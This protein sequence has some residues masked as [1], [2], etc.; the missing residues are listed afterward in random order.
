MIIKQKSLIVAIVSSLIISSVLVLTLI[1]YVAYI[2]L[3]G[4]DF[5]RSYAEALQGVNAKYYAKY[6]EFPKLEARME[7]SG[8]LKG[9]PALVGSLK[10]RGNRTI[11]D[12]LLK[13]RFIDKD[14]A[15][16]YEVDF[17]PHDPSL[18]SAGLNQIAIPRFSALPRLALK[19]GS[20]L[21]FKIIMTNCPHEIMTELEQGKGFAKASDRWVG[22]LSCEIVSVTFNH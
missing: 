18:G 6:V 8:A 20:D 3:R 5:R 1:G 15:V 16:I 21:A 17:H 19:P 11:T 14:G 13:A 9:K 22:K 4:E 7:T 2:K 12:I 10:N